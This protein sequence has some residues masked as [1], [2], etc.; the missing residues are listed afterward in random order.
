MKKLLSVFAIALLSFAP[1]AIA[2]N[3][4]DREMGITAI[5]IINKQPTVNGTYQK[6]REL[7]PN[8]SATYLWSIAEW[9]HKASSTN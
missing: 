5:A 4:T 3:S 2:Q 1:M 6:L 9:V 7:Y 8:E